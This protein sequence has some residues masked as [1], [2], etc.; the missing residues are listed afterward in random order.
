MFHMDAIILSLIIIFLIVL[1]GKVVQEERSR[2]RFKS[3]YW[4]CRGKDQWKC[5]RKCDFIQTLY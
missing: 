2:E 1:F 3:C 5:G 4:F